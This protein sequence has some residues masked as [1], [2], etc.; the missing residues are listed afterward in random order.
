MRSALLGSTWSNA[1]CVAKSPGAAWMMPQARNVAM[2][3]VGTRLN[4]RRTMNGNI[5]R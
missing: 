3:K 1:N 5:V 2:M 4:S